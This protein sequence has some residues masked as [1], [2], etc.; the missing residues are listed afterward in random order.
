MAKIS[1]KLP[2]IE[3]PA[4]AIRFETIFGSQLKSAAPTP[5]RIPATGSTDT[6]SIKDLPIFWR[7]ANVPLRALMIGLVS[8][9][10]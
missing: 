6:G 8:A 1:G 4:L 2:K 5:S 9:D 10:A 3:P 7:L